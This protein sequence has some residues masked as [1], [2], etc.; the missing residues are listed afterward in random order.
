MYMCTLLRQA[1][2]LHSDL[3]GRVPGGGGATPHPNAS[4]PVCSSQGQLKE[5]GP[6]RGTRVWVLISLYPG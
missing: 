1:G 5:N 2:N 6:C 3:G 4:G